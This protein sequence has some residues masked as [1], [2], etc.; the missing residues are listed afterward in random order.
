MDVAM[1]ALTKFVQLE[2]SLKG[3]P[4]LMGEASGNPNLKNSE[5]MRMTHSIICLTME[6]FRYIAGT[7]EFAYNSNI[8]A[9][10]FLADEKDDK[11]NP[12]G[13]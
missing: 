12:F 8:K 4:L 3:A 10:H 5:V 7:I 6:G 13:P 2:F 11:Y 9:A 1:T